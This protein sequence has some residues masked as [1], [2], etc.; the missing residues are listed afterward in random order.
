MPRLASTV[1]ALA[2]LV[3]P[4]SAIADGTVSTSL[5]VDGLVDQPTTFTVD[6]LRKLDAKDVELVSEA[7]AARQYHG[8]LLRDVL[9]ACKPTAKGRF[10]LRRSYIVARAADGYVVVYS[11]GEIFNSAIGDRVLVAYEEG[12]T[13]L[14]DGEGRIALV[15]GGDLRSGPRHV[16]WLESIAMRRVEP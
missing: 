3:A 8:V 4:V 6:D 14:P 13:P 5:R 15:S 2:L 7:G 10:D 11:W 12:G 16:K 1:F 9:A